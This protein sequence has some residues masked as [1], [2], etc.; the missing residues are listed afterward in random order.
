MPLTFRPINT[1][2]YEFTNEEIEACIASTRCFDG[3]GNEIPLT[4]EK[5]KD[6]LAGYRFSAEE[7]ARRP[8]PWASVRTVD[9]FLIYCGHPELVGKELPVC[10]D[11][12]FFGKEV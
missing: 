9:D 4:P 5:A 3:K 11:E 6:V 2:D 1:E 10:E 12:W 7:D 8:M